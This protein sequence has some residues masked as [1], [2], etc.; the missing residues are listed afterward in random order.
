MRT[1][2]IDSA[3]LPLRTEVFVAGALCCLETNSGS[4]VDSLAKCPRRVGVARERS[5]ALKIVVD[6][7][8]VR[9][10]LLAPHFRG[11]H[12]LVFA[13]F[14]E[15]EFF[16]FDLARRAVSGIVSRETA[17][18]PSFWNNLLLPIALG[19]LGP[20]I[21][22]VP[23]HAACLDCGGKGLMIAGE[24]GAGKSTLSVALSQQGFSLV[25]DDW[26]YVALDHKR[27]T[28]YGSPARVKLLP[29]ARHLFP[30]LGNFE[31]QT[32]LN[33]ETAFEVDPSRVFRSPVRSETDPKTILFLERT[34]EAQ[35]EIMPFA[36]ERAR[37]FFESSVERLPHEFSEADA[38]RRETILELT[39]RDCW[40]LRYGGPPQVAVN[41]IRR[42]C[43]GASCGTC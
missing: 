36:K 1:M 37:Q 35:G 13:L 20:T 33:G 42:F 25:S 31:T 23:L 7:L 30:E 9:S 27:I 29:D 11:M 10:P 16:L 12:H 28:A 6:E 40:L 5:F 18:D 39:D 38:R 26:T 22:L 8:A 3:N 32:S 34:R 4:L 14:G 24:S 43:E 19:V 15:Q 17:C 41:A 2:S 21:G